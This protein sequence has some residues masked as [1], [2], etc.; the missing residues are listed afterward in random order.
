VTTEQHLSAAGVTN[1]DAWLG[2]VIV[3]CNKYNINTKKQIAAFI[4]QTAHESGGYTRLTENLNYSA[5]ALMRVWPRRFPTKTVAQ[6]FA[7][8]PE[9]IANQVYSGRMGNGPSQTGEGWRY[10]GRGLKQLTG[11]DNYERCGKALSVNLVENPE[12]LVKPMFAAQ[13]AAWFWSVNNCGPLAEADEFELLTKRIN[14]GLIGLADRKA[15]YDRV[16][17]CL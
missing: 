14:G 11:K 9:L 15:R 4:A 3:A 17:Q 6:A 2:A 10:I 12:L 5:E 13:S 7:R 8:Q 16:M 1:P